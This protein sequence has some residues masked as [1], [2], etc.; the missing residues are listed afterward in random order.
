MKGMV[1]LSH[2]RFGGHEHW[3]RSRHIRNVAGPTLRRIR[4]RPVDIM[5][6]METSA[7]KSILATMALA[8]ALAI[9]WAPA[10]A[11]PLG[12]TRSLAATVETGTTLV[13]HRHYRRHRHYGRRHFGHRHFRFRPYAY[14]PRYY[15]PYYYP[16]YRSYSGFSFY[17]GPRYRHAYY[18]H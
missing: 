4:V 7:M 5:T 15:R 13:G 2:D 6:L 10:Q 14:Y 11:S 1:I 17:I 8:L 9:G 18:Y 12:Q 3:G 16:R